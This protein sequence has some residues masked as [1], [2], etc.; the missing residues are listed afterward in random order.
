MR[1]AS[2]RAPRASAVDEIEDF[3][4]K[5]NLLGVPHPAGGRRRGGALPR[6]GPL[7]QD[8]RLHAHRRRRRPG[9]LPAV[10]AGCRLR[11][12]SSRSSPPRRAVRACP[13]RARRS[14]STRC[15][16]ATTCPSTTRSTSRSPLLALLRAGSRGGS[17]SA[18]ASI[19]WRC[20]ADG[21]REAGRDA[22]RALGRPA[23]L[24]RRR[25]RR[26]SR[27]SSRLCGVPHQER[28]ARVT[29]A[30]TWCARSG[31]TRRRP[32]TG[33]SP[34]SS[35][36]SLDPKP[37]QQAA[38]RSGSAGAPMP[39]C[40]RAGR[41][42]DGWISYVVT[43]ERYR[44]ASRRSRPSPTSSAVRWIPSGAS[45]RPTV[46]ITVVDE[47]QAAARTTAARYL[48]A[49]YKQDV[50]RSGPEVLPARTPRGLRG[51]ARG[52]RRGR[53]ADVRDLFRGAARARAGAAGAIRSRG[54][55]W[56]RTG[57]SEPVLGRPW[58]I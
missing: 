32:S 43:P 45:S 54:R 47:D 21:R 10:T 49:Q 4:R 1:G 24:R 46:L 5:R 51:A 50:R 41:Q 15:G 26:E 53:R 23:R 20:A 56:C 52:L 42:G 2:G 14:A 19:S 38:R 35:R 25:R 44:R 37:V 29:R 40:R 7:R 34:G 11:R 33:A 30:S 3:Y 13:R 8:D 58:R 22:R 9:R 16:P 12:S 31:A 48:E 17:S 36:V 27:R 6:L 28:G 55:P 39:R 57:P 18:P